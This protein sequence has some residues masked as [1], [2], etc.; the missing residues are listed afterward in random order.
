MYLKWKLY[1]LMRSVFY[2][3]YQTLL[4]SLFYIM[5]SVLYNATLSSLV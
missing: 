3:I 2:V 1:I 4:A 5:N